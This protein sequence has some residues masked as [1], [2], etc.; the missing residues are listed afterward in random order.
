MSETGFLTHFDYSKRI[1][2]GMN[3]LVF[4]GVNNFLL[5]SDADVDSK[6]MNLHI[7]KQYPY[8]F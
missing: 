7:N 6:V 1:T 5:R 8:D 2:K 3:I 4:P